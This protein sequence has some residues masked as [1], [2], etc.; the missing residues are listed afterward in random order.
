MMYPYSKYIDTL[1][2]MTKSVA[3]RHDKVVVAGDFNAKSTCWGGSTTDK[4]G[5]VLMEALSGHRVFPVR[6]K[7]KYT[8]FMNG[9]TSFPDIISVSNKVSEIHAGSAVLDKYSASDHLYVLYRFK[10]RKTRIVSKFYRY[11]TKDMSP[12]EFLSRF[13]DT[14]K[15]EDLNAAI[16][17]D[18]AEPLQESIEGMCEGMLRKLNCAANRKYANYWWNPVIAELRA[19]AHK[20]LRKVTRERKKNAGNTEPLVNAY[21]EIRRQLKK[22]IA[23]SKKTA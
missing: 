12:E 15:K 10:A 9:K 3:R 8:F 18:G 16:G 14:L 20:A 23:R 2:T 11:V 21:K 5:R 17:A 1:S 19:Q 22:E 6:L 4:R 13:D 7:E